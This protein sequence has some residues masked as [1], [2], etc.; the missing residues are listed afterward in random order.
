MPYPKVLP[1][2]LLRSMIWLVN[3]VI[4]SNKSFNNKRIL[5]SGHGTP[6]KG[7]E[8]VCWVKDVRL[9]DFGKVSNLLFFN[10]I[11][12]LRLG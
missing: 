8:E 4:L 7:I 5:R 12:Q 6:L 1:I 3:T 11:L 9:S 2:I 10:N